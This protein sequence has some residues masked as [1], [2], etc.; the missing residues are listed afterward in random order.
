VK[1]KKFTD[2]TIRYGNLCSTGE[3]Q[4]VQEALGDPNWKR[5][6][7]DEY[8]ALLKN[9]TWHLVPYKPGMNLIDCSGSLRL[10][11]KQMGQSID[12]RVDW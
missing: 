1:P 11:G 9:D 7:E 5:A 3:P 2:G 8:A 4:S 10:K 6:M 12:I